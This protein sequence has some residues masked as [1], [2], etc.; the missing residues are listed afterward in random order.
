VIPLP[1]PWFFAMLAV[2]VLSGLVWGLTVGRRG[3]VDID[4]S[5]TPAAG[6]PPDEV[7]LSR[8]EANRVA[9]VLETLAPTVPDDDLFEL[10]RPTLD[11][12]EAANEVAKDAAPLAAMLRSR[13]AG[14]H[15]AEADRS[16]VDVVDDRVPP[17]TRRADITIT[18]DRAADLAEYCRASVT[19]WVV[20]AHL[21]SA[22]GLATAEVQARRA[23][24]LT[25]MLDVR[26]TGSA[27]P[28]E[29]SFDQAV[30]LA[31]FCTATAQAW[32][33]AAPHLPS[34]SS[35]ALSAEDAPARGRDLAEFLWAGLTSAGYGRYGA[36]ARRRPRPY[37]D[38]DR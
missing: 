12:I 36:A 13:L 15:A 8:R 5:P 7:R 31:E 16:P 37:V 24:E 20:M 19:P 26:R 23:G 33:T 9:Y 34:T 25:A 1:L 30:A 11:E 35:L 27:D 6:L 28:V 4:C 3:V 32:S 17:P 2:T 22:G 29:L 10:L 38:G 18:D 14:P 21:A